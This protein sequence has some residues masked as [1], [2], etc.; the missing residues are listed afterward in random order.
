M[1]RLD[2]FSLAANNRPWTPRPK[3]R[4][5][6]EFDPFWMAGE[7]C[8]VAKFDC[9][10]RG[11]G[12]NGLQM[13]NGAG[14]APEKIRSWPRDNRGVR[15]W[16]WLGLTLG[17][18]IL[19]FRPGPAAADPTFDTTT[20]ISFF[21]NVASR[22]L[23]AQ[24]NVNLTQLQIYPT[25]QYTPAV[26]RLLQ[27]TA[28]ILDAENTNFYPSVF[29][30]LFAA[31]AAGDVYICGYAQ[32]TNV[33]GPSDP[34]L[35]TPYA[36][37]ELVDFAG[38][39]P[40][41]DGNG[42]VNVY[43]VP[44]VIGAKQGLP[45][46]NQ[47]SL[48]SA[49]QVTRKLELTRTS[50][51]VATASYST[52]QEYIIGPITNEVGISFWNPYSSAYPRPLQVVVS[53]SLNEFMTNGYHVWPL[54]SDASPTNFYTNVVINAWPGSQW[55]GTPP[56]MLPQMSSFFS[57]NWGVLY[58]SPLAYDFATHNFLNYTCFNPEMSN[59]DQIGL[60]VTNYLQ[61]YIL[62]GGN[63]IDY[64]ELCSAVCG[65][66]NQALADWNYPQVGNV[67]YQWSTNTL[68]TAS[69]VPFGVLNQLYISGHPP[70]PGGPTPVS[71]IPLG[72]QWSTALTVMGLITP[73]AEA[74]F[75]DGFFTAS[76]DYQGKTYVNRQMSMQAPYTPTRTV[77]VSLL[78]QAN[79][80]LVHYLAS[81]LNGQTGTRAIWAAQQVA[82]NC[83]WTHSDDPGATQPMP[84][85][86][87]TP[88]K[89]RYQPWGQLG[90]MA[91][92]GATVDQNAY[93]L[94]YKDPLVWTADGWNFPTGQ[95]WNLSW[96][97][98]VHR[99]TPWQTIYL[100]STNILAYSNSGFPTGLV[101][102]AAWTGDLLQDAATGA[103]LDATESAPVYDWQLV[104]L[105]AAVLNTNDLRT[106]FP[107]SDPDPNAWAMELDG[108]TALT[109]IVEYPGA[110]IS[111]EFSPIVI[112]SNS[113]QAVMIA[114]AIESAKAVF[115]GQVFH[116][117][118]DILAAPQLTVESPFLNV[119]PAAQQEYAI[120][121]QAYEAIPSQLLPRLRMDPWGTMVSAN[122]QV[123]VEFSGYDGHDYAVQ[124]SPDLV[125]WTSVSTNSPVNG[126]FD[127][128]LPAAGSPAAQFYR[129]VL[130]R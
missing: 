98:Q 40:V 33:S 121:D 17:V 12:F 130:V 19:L 55:S 66:L 43:G 13:R 39:D 63:V 91:A 71:E 67:Y 106:Q 61:G 96:L 99:G 82:T 14:N 10:I 128:N 25:N 16:R 109:N 122:G 60:S 36:P 129:T 107:V 116:G 87:A 44:W 80:P 47:L 45:N 34:Q 74:A 11:V 92:M 58:Q 24:L 31:D 27:V 125:S 114:D 88:L 79:D 75:F 3:V 73:G 101:T 65:G 7:A 127:F 1:C 102:W 76:F 2:D 48:I 113:A 81:D 41:A 69:T 85:P 89:G 77:Y 6:R 49:A 15:G 84:T 9:F 103:Y 119:N 126:V 68:G 52:N 104:S 42:L 4:F 90:Q 105:L 38:M 51:D 115:L 26:H 8:G 21:T 110:Y 20:P 72:G 53:D 57:F 28:N 123:Q 64:V 93:N 59:L 22:L 83:V 94:A 117:I 62:D 78:L 23:S 50:L 97:G 124:A 108:L 86:P 118:G 100:K 56:N 5:K 37:A 111:P 30:P 32:V 95:T 46:F 35:A 112:S 54:H 18:A 29:R 120:N 70:A